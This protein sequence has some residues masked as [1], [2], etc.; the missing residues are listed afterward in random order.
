M[1]EL[2]DR[3]LPGSSIQFYAATFMVVIFLVAVAD[4]VLSLTPAGGFLG[5]PF[6]YILVLFAVLPFLM[7]AGELKRVS[8]RLDALEKKLDLGEE[9]PAPGDTPES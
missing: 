4:L 6:S 3:I 7:V 2:D 9:T 5:E 8:E 1:S